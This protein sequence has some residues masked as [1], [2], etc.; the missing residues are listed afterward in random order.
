MKSSHPRAFLR[1]QLVSLLARRS[2][3][4]PSELVRELRISQPTFSRL[5]ASLQGEVLSFGHTR[6]RRYALARA[7]PG[8]R[9]PLVIYE[10]RPRGEK[11]RRFGELSAIGER[12][13]CLASSEGEKFFEDLPWFLRGARPSGFLGRLVPRRHPDLGLPDDIRMWSA[14]HVLRFASRH[15]WDPPG[16]FIIGDDACSRFLA[17]VEQPSNLV[18]AAERHE[19]YP[20]IVSDLLSFGSAGSSAAGEQPKFLATR[21]EGDRLTPVLVKFSPA[22]DETIGRRVADLLV[23]E[24]VALAT[25]GRHGFRVPVASVS[26]FGGRMFLEIERFD[27]DGISCRT[28]QVAL[29]VLDAEFAGTELT[30]WTVSAEVLAA[31]NVVPRGEVPRVRWLETFGRLIGNTDMHFG[32]L[33]FLLDGVRL[34]TLAPVYDMLPMHYHPRQGELPRNDH[35]LPIL[36]PEVADVAGSALDATLEYWGRLANDTRVSESFREIAARSLRRTLALR[37][38]VDS[39]PITIPR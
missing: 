28:G 13:F 7:I 33:A 16:V 2:P 37:P 23:A 5:V 39:L 30:S 34:T 4:S 26:P 21:G 32:N 18:V 17:E 14:D 19:R 22:M 38:R 11:L 1:G 24:E 25:L 15:G 27:R 31:K 20:A 36:G 6:A 8:V 35:D 9:Q 3:A 29:E 12:G 10:V